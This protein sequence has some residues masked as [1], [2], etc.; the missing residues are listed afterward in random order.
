MTSIQT[1]LLYLL[2]QALFGQPAGITVTQEIMAEAKAQAVSS[3]ISTDYDTL[4]QNI[5]IAFAHAEL[6]KVLN[7]VPFTTFKGYSSAYYYPNPIMRPM[8]DIDYIV[9]P[10][11]Y[12]ESV[13]LLEKHGW[14]K[15]NHNHSRHESFVKSGALFELHHEIKGIPNGAD[16]IKTDSTIAEE[17]V[18]L[19]LSDLISTAITVDTQQG[20]IIIPDAF[21]HCL[22][23]LLHIAGHII[24][25]GGIGLRHLCDWAVF[26][27][28]VDINRYKQK[29]E[30]VGL[31]TFA[32]QLTAVSSKFLGLPKQSWASEWPEEFLDSFMED[33][34][35]AGNFGRKEAGRRATLT[36]ERS[37]FAEMTRKHYPAA[38]NAFLLPFFRLSAH[39]DSQ[40]CPRQTEN[41]RAAMKGKAPGRE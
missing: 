13:E 21:H 30:E 1:Q 18:R 34:L 14:K 37:S 17:K 27:S 2:S 39:I 9:S 38:K 26:V 20:P 25:D 31:W 29:L 36:L 28:R 11:Y 23:M 12:A 15:T 8:G 6:T 40:S 22:T 33:I 24:N 35:A 19:L 3:L 10:E 4:A 5:R 7:D 16:G 41:L 32:C